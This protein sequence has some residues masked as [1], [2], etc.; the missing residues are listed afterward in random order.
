MS[1]ESE[2]FEDKK[3]E[4]TKKN[5]V[6]ATGVFK[7]VERKDNNAGIRFHMLNR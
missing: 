2:D 4:E 5:L 3:E 6:R 1:E 7:T